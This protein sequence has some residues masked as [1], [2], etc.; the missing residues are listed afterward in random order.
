MKITLHGIKISACLS[1]S[2]LL[3]AGCRAPPAPRLDQTIEREAAA[4]RSAYAAGSPE[5]AAAAFERALQRARL[6]DGGEEIARCA[7]NLAACLAALRRWDEAAGR[8]AEAEAA[9]GA[10]RPPEF[11]L[12]RAKILRGAGRTNDAITLIRGRL[13]DN[14][15]TPRAA[16]RRPAMQVLL[17]DM[18]CDAG[19]HAGA[20]AAL[21]QVPEKS[22]AAADTLTHADWLRIQGRIFA[23]K[24]DQ[25]AAGHYFDQAAE[26]FRQ[27]TRYAAMAA[28]LADAG[29]AY[30]AQGDRAAAADRLYRAARS[31][32]EQGA[33]AQARA[34]LDQ[35]RPLAGG[36][37]RQLIDS[38]AAKNDQADQDVTNVHLNP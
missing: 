19:D 29:R 2:V 34:L 36:A 37:A 4:G 21:A 7:Y 10:P 23:A 31:L 3:L 6:I 11:I 9:A 32:H 20:A 14:R 38:L 25:S 35:A 30:A 22:A 27:A 33:P 1:A 15:R 26:T 17:A 28:C 13:D 12:L 24:G 16:E 18:L 5:R 8:L